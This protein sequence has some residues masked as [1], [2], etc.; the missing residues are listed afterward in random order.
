MR[1]FNLKPPFSSRCPLAENFKDQTGAINH[2]AAQRIFEIALLNRRKRP[3]DNHK[4]CFVQITIGFE[5]LNLTATEQGI[6][7]DCSYGYNLGLSNDQSNC[8]C[9]SASLLE[10]FFGI[11]FITLAVDIRTQHERPRAARYL[12][13]L[14]VGKSQTSSPSSQPSL[15]STG[16]SGWMVET[17]CL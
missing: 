15:R 9:K 17:A 7:T 6:W 8:Q 5:L 11:K 14:V 3:V 4:L 2:L 16:L 1:Q 13:T 10:P 12:F